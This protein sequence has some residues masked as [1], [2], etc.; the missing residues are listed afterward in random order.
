MKRFSRLFLLAA[1]AAAATLSNAA[2]TIRCALG[3]VISVDELPLLVA[4]GKD[5][6]VHAGARR[7]EHDL[8]GKIRSSSPSS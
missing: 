2:T 1:L 5:I 8:P 4:V 7:H 3:D 6:V